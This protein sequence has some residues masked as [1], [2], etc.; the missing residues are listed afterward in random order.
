MRLILFFL[1]TLTLLSAKERIIT[2]SPS[3]SEIVFSLGKGEELVGVSSY[4]TYP[5]EVLNVEKIGGYFDPNLEKILSLEPTLVIGQG[6][7]QKFLS[8]LNALGIKT[9]SVELSRFE[10]I[11]ASIV[12]IGKE[13]H[14]TKAKD[15]VAQMERAR[16]EAPKL[17]KPESV[18]I[19]FG[20]NYDLRSNIYVAGHDLY[21]E[22]MLEACNA[23]NAYTPRNFAQPILGYEQIVALN[24]D[25]VILLHS[26]IT[27]KPLDE[28]LLNETWGAL[29]INAAKNNNI[30]IA[31]ADLMSIPSAKLALA[32]PYL[33][34]L[35]VDDKR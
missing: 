17:K 19:A 7:L 11:E 9:L 16:L 24:P 4:A 2:L 35:I 32:I 12:K 26:K 13:I 20:V 8:Q 22:Q 14:S 15:L 29:P 25:K 10:D 21:F 18:L 3:L 33:C 31:N 23:T 5:K 1:F 27:D 6:H 30:T 34:A 28:K